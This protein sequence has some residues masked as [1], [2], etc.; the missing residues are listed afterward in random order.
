MLRCGFM[1]RQEKHTGSVCVWGGGGGEPGMCEHTFKLLSCSSCYISIFNAC[2]TFT[3]CGEKP[4]IQLVH[5]FV[6]AY[7][8]PVAAARETAAFPSTCLC[9]LIGP[10][11][12]PAAVLYI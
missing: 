12:Y 8:K 6:E 3:Y 2:I 10:S 7:F 4:S 11:S 9:Y 5:L 1:N